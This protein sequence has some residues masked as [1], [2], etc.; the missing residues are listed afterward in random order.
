LG[1]S[2]EKGNAYLIDGGGD[3]RYVVGAVADGTGRSDALGSSGWRNLFGVDPYRG[4]LTGFETGVFSLLLDLGGA[5]QYLARDFATGVE[6]PHQAAANGRTWFNPDS[7]TAAPGVAIPGFRY[8]DAR[9][10]GL[11]VDRDNGRIPEFDRIPPAATPVPTAPADASRSRSL[12]D[13]AGWPVDDGDRAVERMDEGR[14]LYR[15]PPG[16]RR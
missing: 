14:G 1:R 6:R 9:F 4:Y 2:A 15:V 11:G 10:Y 8:A 16:D 7:R 13:Q 3:D 5:D 12:L